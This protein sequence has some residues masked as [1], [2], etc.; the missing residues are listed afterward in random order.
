M[1]AWTSSYALSL[2]LPR[3]NPEQVTPGL[4]IPDGISIDRQAL[5]ADV[6]IRQI[7]RIPHL[8][9]IPKTGYLRIL[10]DY[11]AEHLNV[12]DDTGS[13]LLDDMNVVFHGFPLEFNF[14]ARF[15]APER[16]L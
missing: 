4:R 12:S 3:I 7:D 10:N 13:L 6:G 5:G 9:F 16:V 8:L 14:T 11:S 15:V 1:K 2:F